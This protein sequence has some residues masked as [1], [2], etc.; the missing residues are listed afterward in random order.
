MPSKI[1]FLILIFFGFF[2]GPVSAQQEIE[3]KLNIITREQWDAAPPK[4]EMIPHIPQFITIHHTGTTSKPGVS[5]KSKMQAL[6]K[7]SFSEGK[8]GNGNPK[9]AWADVPYHYYIASNGSIAEGRK[10]LFEGDSNTDYDL[11]GH[12]LIVLEGNF[13]VENLSNEQFMSLLNLVVSLSQE[14]NVPPEKITGHKDQAETLCPGSNLY[15][16]LPLLRKKVKPKETKRVIIGAEQ[17]FDA[18]YF[19]L[20]RNKRIGL[21]TNHTGVLPNGTHLIDELYQNPEV[22]L[23]LL[24]GPEHGLRGEQD[25][26]VANSVDPKT[27]IPIISLYGKVRKPSE[28]MLENIDVLIFDIQDVGARYYTY[29]KTMLR[30][31]EAA[32]ENNIP[33]IVLDRPNPIT[34]IQ[35]A[36]PVGKPLEPKTEIGNIPVTHGMTVGELSLLFNAERKKNALPVA[37]QHV[38]PMKNY[39]RSQWYD[40]TGLPWIK[41][42]PNMLRLS[43]A[44]VYPGT[45]L[46]E[47]TNISEGRGTL[48]PFEKF[49][50][51]W[52]DG[53]KLAEELNEFKLPG[54]NFEEKTFVPDSIVDGI[55]IYPPKFLGEEVHG[56]KMNI[57]NRNTFKPVE[58]GIYILYVL[59]KL[60][61]EKLEF[62]KE[63]LDGLLGTSEVRKALIAGKTPSEIIKDWEQD[64]EEFRQK[65]EKFLLY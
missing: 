18:K 25:T 6:Q 21:V 22:R 14:Y 55:E 24:F 31:Q 2:A 12:I 27:E 26:H 9:K 29:I 39:F 10:L 44:I 23:K 15:N 51:P 7:F 28:E 43:T 30:V 41:P 4:S 5:I 13:E 53:E 19:P 50:A 32:A 54:V 64:Q 56:V 49:G 3:E 36:G 37:E 52:I 8:L 46:L 20:I 33:F 40:E 42:S 61:P 35:T 57:T 62:R 59:N 47:G 48:L 38:I 11:T 1:P 58:T 45:C 60:Y 65:R 16:V 63:R 17:L 34:G